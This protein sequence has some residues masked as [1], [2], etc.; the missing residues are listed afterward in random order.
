MRVRGSFLLLLLSLSP[1]LR[2]EHPEPS[3]F[4]SFPKHHAPYFIEQFCFLIQNVYISNL[5]VMSKI[6]LW[7]HDEKLT[8]PNLFVPSLPPSLSFSLPFSFLSFPFPSLSS[9][10]QI[11]HRASYTCSQVS[12]LPSQVLGFFFSW[13]W[14]LN[15]GFHICQ[16]GKPQLTL[17]SDIFFY[18]ETFFL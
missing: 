13:S 11:E 9:V 2:V 1:Y 6:C 8:K 3:T 15:S 7:F 5:I 18:L 10:L 16:T 4:P 14:C 12:T 17:S